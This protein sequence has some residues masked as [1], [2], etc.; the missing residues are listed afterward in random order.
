MRPTAT[1]SRHATALRR[2]A[3]IFP[4]KKSDH[5][6]RLWF[7]GLA[8]IVI[9]YALLGSLHPVFGDDPFFLLNDARWLVEHHEIP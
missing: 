2:N 3:K 4:A 6:E 1:A 9:G 8:A 7:V 5:W